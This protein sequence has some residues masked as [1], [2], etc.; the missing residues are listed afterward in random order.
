MSLPETIDT[1][2]EKVRPG[3]SLLVPASRDAFALSVLTVERVG[4]YEHVGK[5]IFHCGHVVMHKKIG[6]LVQVVES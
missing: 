1:P 2:A 6:Q 5:V 4:I 3:S